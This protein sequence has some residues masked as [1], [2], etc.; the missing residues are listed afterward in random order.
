[1][2]MCP[3]PGHPPWILWKGEDCPKCQELGIKA[4]SVEY[5]KQDRV[6]TTLVEEGLV[7]E[8]TRSRALMVFS[9]PEKEKT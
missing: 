7:F 9:L 8:P 4:F 6:R 3:M 2:P 5:D 1:M